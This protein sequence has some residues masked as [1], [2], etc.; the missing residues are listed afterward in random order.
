[1]ITIQKYVCAQSLDDAYALN[2]N[3]RNSIVG[4]MMW[5]RLGKGNVNTA[6]DLCDLG[7]NTIEETVDSFVIGAM[8]TLRDIEQHEGLNKYTNGAIKNAV[9]DIVGVQFRN[10]ATVG[11]SVWGRFGFSDVLTVLLAMDTCVQ[12]Y[13]GGIVSLEEFVKMKY[14]RDILVNIIIKKSKLNIIYSSMR[15]QKTDFPVIACA[16]AQVNDEY[17]V[18]VGARPSKA[19]IVRDENKILAQGITH[20]SA[21]QFA[22]YVAQKTPPASNLRGSS[23]YRSHLIEVLTERTLNELR[24]F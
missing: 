2:Q 11:G 7:L 19:M 3:K 16:V 12:L 4:G 24:G 17:R 21:K 1:M 8:T 20:E 14:D 9:K 13:K 6:I 15:N 23:A 18:S 22:Q 5:I 10:M